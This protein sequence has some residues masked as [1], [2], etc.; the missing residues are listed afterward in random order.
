MESTLNI[1]ICEDSKEEEKNILSLLEKSSIFNNVTVFHSGEELL[2]F[3]EPEKFDLLLMD[4]FMGGINGIETVEKIR[5]FDENIPIAFVTTSTDFTLESYRLSALKYIEKPCR[6]K[7]IEDI[8]KLAML[9]KESAPGLI[10]HKNRK[11]IKLKFS[12]IIYIETASRKLNIHMNNSDIIQVN[13]KLSSILPQ[14]ENEPF[15]SPHK[16]FSVNLAHVQYID[17][18]LKTFIMDNGDNVPIRRELMGAAKKA[19]ENYLF[20]KTR[21]LGL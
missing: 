6:Q 12:Q 7:D 13:E 20:S 21:R 4:I 17:H 18:E 14:L 15:I 2:E 3:Y 9:E 10:V 5:K 1:A 11:D 19:L 16:S 8:L